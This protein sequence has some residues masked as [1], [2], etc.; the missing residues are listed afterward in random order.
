MTAARRFV[1]W[2]L[3]DPFARAPRP[4]DEAM[5]DGD[6]RVRFSQRVWPTA[7]AGHGLDPEALAEAFAMKPGDVVVVDGP[8]ALANPGAKVRDAEARLRA[9]GRTPDVLPVPGA[10]FAGFVRGSVLL[11][12]ALRAHARVPMLDLDTPS[13]SHARLFEAFPGA[14]W[15]ALAV[16]KLG[17]KS[18]PEGRA[19][20]QALLESSGLRFGDSGTCTHDQLDAALCAWL[21]WLTRTRPRDVIA[22]GRPL[23]HDTDGTLREGRILDLDRAHAV[24]P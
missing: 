1:G 19:R 3:T 11:F 17:A 14:T 18:T 15:R 6:G 23:T 4:V 2:D 24:S 16:E 7:R 21:G 12:A 5:V 8:Q 20:R 10:P 22:V 13:L 9:P